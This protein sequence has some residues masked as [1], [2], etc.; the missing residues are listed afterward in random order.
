MQIAGTWA[1]CPDG[2]TRPM[3]AVEIVKGDGSLWSEYFLVDSGADATVFNCGV[4]PKLNL[5][6]APSPPGYNL[7]GI[8]GSSGGF[9]HVDTSLQFTTTD[10]GKVRVNGQFA[11]FTQPIGYTYS[12][13][14]REV[15]NLFD[16]ILSWPRKEVWFLAPNHGHQITSP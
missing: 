5:P 14:G 1:K 3:V 12:I 15:L 6:I 13:L 11:A 2:T 7:V 8:T 4:F 16:V 10:G 9:V